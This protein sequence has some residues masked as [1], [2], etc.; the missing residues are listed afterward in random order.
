MVDVT[1]E[2]L[3]PWHF[4]TA[5]TIWPKL[6]A[7]KGLAYKA[8]S[9]TWK[10]ACIIFA[11]YQTH[12]CIRKFSED[13]K[14]TDVAIE[15][16]SKHPYPAVSICYNDW[17]KYSA[18]LLGC[19]LTMDSYYYEYKWTSEYCKDGQ[20]VYEKMVGQPSDFIHS[21]DILNQ[22]DNFPIDVKNENS[23]H[24]KDD[25]SNGRCYTVK[26]PQEVTEIQIHFTYPAYIYIHGPNSFFGNDYLGILVNTSH[27]VAV[28]V[29]HEIFEVVDF[30]GEACNHY[31]NGRDNCI[32]SAVSQEALTNLGCTSPYGPDKSNICTDTEKAHMADD[33]FNNISADN[34]SLAN[35]L[36]PKSCRNL[37]FSFGRFKDDYIEENAHD[38]NYDY[39][40]Q[41]AHGY[42]SISFEKFIKVS[43]SK[44]SY[45]V[46][47]LVAEV[48]GYVGLFLGVSVNQ[49]ADL[50]KSSFSKWNSFR[51]KF[52]IQI[53]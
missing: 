36:C 40:E 8:F 31:E 2:E 14:T 48:G 11:A 42:I 10:I 24:F 30:D 18:N 12:K 51:K 9:L 37:M 53:A 33:I 29:M 46:L 44:F 35:E 50:I 45:N 20:M 1:A 3:I 4:F 49:F 22:Q 28:N 23:F 34:V 16:A 52:E 39:S 47:E 19:N 25:S 41:N 5:K 43:R 38:Y 7:K 32:Y 17:G 21:L 13:P 26:P 6:L 27:N 15:H